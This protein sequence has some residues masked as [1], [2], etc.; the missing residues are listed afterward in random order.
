MIICNR[1]LRRSIHTVQCTFHLQ[2]FFFS[3]NFV[4]REG[5]GHLLH[6]PVLIIKFLSWHLITR[7]SQPQGQLPNIRVTHNTKI[8]YHLH[9]LSN[10]REEALTT[11]ILHCLYTTHYN[12]IEAYI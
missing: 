1:M 12:Y 7:C 6:L 9:G 2:F 5:Q 11:E 8:T 4:L 3:A 10:I